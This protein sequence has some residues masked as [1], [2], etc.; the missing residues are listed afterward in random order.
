MRVRRERCG[1]RVFRTSGSDVSDW[2]VT[3][4]GR[5]ALTGPELL[6]LL[7]GACLTGTSACARG[8]SEHE[9]GRRGEKLFD[10]DSFLLE[11]DDFSTLTGVSP[12]PIP[13]R[14]PAVPTEG[15]LRRYAGNRGKKNFVRKYTQAI[16]RLRGSC[17]R[18]SSSK[19]LAASRPYRSRRC[20]C[21]RT[22][23]PLCNEDSQYRASA[24]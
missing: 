2:P 24:C 22:F 6:T 7:A 16:M 21:C 5:C 23:S 14:I 12:V 19:Y 11:P 4:A 20:R 1:E 8:W 18:A 15:M 13:L 9:W 3:E 17:A 10:H